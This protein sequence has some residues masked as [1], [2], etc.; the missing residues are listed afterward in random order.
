M[1]QF[2]FF[3]RQSR[4]LSTAEQ[5]QRTAEVVAWVKQ[6]IADGRKLEPRVLDP[7]CERVVLEGGASPGNGGTF[8]AINFLEAQDFAEAVRI[9]RTHPG[10]RYGVSIEVRP[11]ANPLGA[12]NTQQASNSGGMRPRV[13]LVTL[14]VDD[15]ERSLRFYR[16]GLGLSTN[17]IVGQEFEYGAVVF[18]E[19]E[20]GL[21][22]AL[23][24]RKSIARDTGIA[25]TSAS[26]TEFTLGHNV[27]TK[28]DVD[29]VMSRAK[30][31]GATIVK[32]AGDTF[33]GG[34]AGVFQDPDQHLWEV[35]WNPQLLP[36]D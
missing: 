22:L 23:W 29:A 8:V 4:E 6:Q 15:L 1:K 34:Y 28:A 20:G 25:Q 7:E 9:A 17:G 35:A 12:T 30:A 2:A 16:D 21:R 5:Q 33:W 14:G 32:P 19:L 3:F 11:W 26:P 24:P 18:F 31:A 36:N 13:T 10:L 27:R